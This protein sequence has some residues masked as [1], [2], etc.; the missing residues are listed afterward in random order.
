MIA[1]LETF[2]LETTAA[3]NQIITQG[4]T[5][6]HHGDLTIALAI[7][8]FATEHLQ[9]GIVGEHKLLGFY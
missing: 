4:R 2:Q 8:A 7:A 1:E 5:G 9:P 3:G 6:K